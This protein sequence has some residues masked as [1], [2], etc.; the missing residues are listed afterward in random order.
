MNNMTVLFLTVNKDELYDA[1]TELGKMPYKVAATV[2]AYIAV[3][4]EE[5]G[6]SLIRSFQK[7]HVALAGGMV[8]LTNMA[9]SMR[10][11]V[12][13]LTE[14]CLQEKIMRRD[15][16]GRLELTPH[17][18]NHEKLGRASGDL[19]ALSGSY[20]E[21]LI[22]GHHVQPGKCRTMLFSPDLAAFVYSLYQMRHG[23]CR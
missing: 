21:P 2:S 3:L 23:P 7:K 15:E 10:L 18:V 4:E 1:L 22:T 12:P 6:Y 16:E 14:F 19:N 9:V 20:D 11:S 8:S 13:Q 5:A 17:I